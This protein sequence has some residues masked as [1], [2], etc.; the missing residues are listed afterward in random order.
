MELVQAPEF[1]SKELIALLAC[2]CE[3]LHNS[4][5]L[6]EVENLSERVEELLHSMTCSEF[7]DHFFINGGVNT[8]FEV[9]TAIT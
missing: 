7:S 8:L 5:R 6:G 1:S 4:E 9:V 2:I 3:C